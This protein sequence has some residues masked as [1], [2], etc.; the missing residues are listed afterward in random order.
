MNLKNALKL[1]FLNNNM[2][3]K[4]LIYRLFIFS[5]FSVLSYFLLKDLLNSFTSI[6]LSKQYVIDTLNLIKNYF[7]NHKIKLFLI[8]IC[9]FI[10]FIVFCNRCR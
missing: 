5:V 10:Y 1:T 3:I 4:S 6:T 7:V 9:L 8:I 2:V